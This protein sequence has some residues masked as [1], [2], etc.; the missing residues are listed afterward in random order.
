MSKSLCGFDNGFLDTITKSEANKENKNKLDFIKI[1]NF[2][3]Q[4]ALIKKEKQPME[5]KKTF[6]NYIQ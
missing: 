1:R 5:V 2:A 4:R 3:L 6:A